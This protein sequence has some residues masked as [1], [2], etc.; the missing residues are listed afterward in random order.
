MITREDV[1]RRLLAY[2][3][4]DVTLAD[5]VDWAEYAMMDAEFEDRHSDTI[6]YVIAQIGVA[7]VRNFRSD[8][9]RLRAYYRATRIFR[10]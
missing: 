1:T 4:R 3:N 2:L 7:D 5:L 8:L 10:T 9:G 6:R